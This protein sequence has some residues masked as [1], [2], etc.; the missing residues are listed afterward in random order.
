MHGLVVDNT[1]CEGLL[2]SVAL[3]VLFPSSVLLRKRRAIGYT[4]HVGKTLDKL[5]GLQDNHIHKSHT[6]WAERTDS[7]NRICSATANH[8]RYAHLTFV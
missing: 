3:Y 5:Y 7:T 2:A 4:K 8:E 1:K 6:Y